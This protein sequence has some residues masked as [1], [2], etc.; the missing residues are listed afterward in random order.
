MDPFLKTPVQ[1][2]ERFWLV[3]Y[4]RQITSLRHVWSHPDFGD[5]MASPAPVD[6]KAASERWLRDWCDMTD[7]APTYEELIAVTN[8]NSVDWEIL[9]EYLICHS[10]SVSGSIPA[11]VW[12]HVMVITGDTMA[13]YPSY[14]SCSC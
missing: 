6:D 8:G 13:S 7:G 9:D 10:S 4:P 5:K 14:F 12:H 2:G 3:V 1:E 11:I